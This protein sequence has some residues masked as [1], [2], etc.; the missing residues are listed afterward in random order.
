[1]LGG[2]TFIPTFDFDFASGWEDI[3]HFAITVVR[4]M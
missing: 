4:Q 3:S 2:D 1:M